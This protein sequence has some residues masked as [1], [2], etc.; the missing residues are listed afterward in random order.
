MKYFEVLPP[1]QNM[2]LAYLS[3]DQRKPISYGIS[4]GDTRDNLP[5]Q[6]D[7]IRKRDAESERKRLE[8]LSKPEGKFFELPEA[9]K[10]PSTMMPRS[11]RDAQ[12]KPEATGYG[13]DYLELPKGYKPEGP[14]GFYST[15]PTTSPSSTTNLSSTM[16]ASSP[17]RS[18]PKNSQPPAYAAMQS[19]TPQR[20]QSESKFS[21]GFLNYL[22]QA[23]ATK[24]RQ[25]EV[26]IEKTGAETGL[27]GVQTGRLASM[28]PYE[29]AQIAAQTRL[30]G[31]QSNRIDTLTPFEASQMAAQTGLYGAQATLAGTQ[32]A[33]TETLTPYEASQMNAETELTGAQ[34]SRIKTLTPYEAAQ[35]AAQTS[36]I[37]TLTPYEA[38]QMGAQTGLYGS[39]AAF[40]AAQA[41]RTGTLTPF[42]ASQI[43]A[44]TGLTEAQTGRIQTLTPYEAAQMSAQ[45]PT[46]SYFSP[47]NAGPTVT[48]KI[49]PPPTRKDVNVGLGGPTY[50][51]NFGSYSGAPA[52]G[53][54]NQ[55]SGKGNK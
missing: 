20:S 25:G 31:S 8:G 50:T 33:R 5:A 10:N 24:L 47:I 17:Y 27:L 34:S 43:K 48:T 49:I 26:D 11:D 32:A 29:I 54:Y 1:I 16:P 35:M 30:T 23:R 52:S 12:G 44:G 14:A 42:E 22:D 41:L 15:S 13:K 7:M 46:M 55:R 45:T 21:E 38:A 37:N 18:A 6:Q 4:Y 2:A 19:P 36:R 51:G 9:Y 40:S 53:K 3:P 39:Q 28:T